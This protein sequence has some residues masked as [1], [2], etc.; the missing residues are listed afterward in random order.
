VLGFEC[1]VLGLLVKSSFT[2]LHLHHIFYI[3]K[4]IHVNITVH[5]CN[6]DCSKKIICYFI[7]VVL[8]ADETLDKVSMVDR[9]FAIQDMRVSRMKNNSE[10]LNSVWELY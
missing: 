2:E 4:K 3:L 5:L 6:S 9:C 1:K 7:S 8:N 10:R